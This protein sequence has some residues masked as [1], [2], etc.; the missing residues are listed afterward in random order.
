LSRLITDFI[1]N[2]VRCLIYIFCF[3][4]YKSDTGDITQKL[5]DPPFDSYADQKLYFLLKGT[6]LYPSMNYLQ[7]N[8]YYCNLY[9]RRI[10]SNLTNWVLKLW[11]I[12]FWN[13]IYNPNFLSITK[14]SMERNIQSF[15][16]IVTK[17]SIFLHSRN[18]NKIAIKRFF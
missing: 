16:L 1:C 18:W 3:T 7:Y 10:K 15:C 14:G 8:I 2:Y 6:P 11:N 5:R 9:T 13:W 12:S 4:T 17:S